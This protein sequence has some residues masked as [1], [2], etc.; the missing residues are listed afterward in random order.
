MRNG[1]VARTSHDLLQQCP[2]A[3]LAVDLD[4][5]LVQGDMLL[6]GLAQALRH[7]PVSALPL[8]GALLLKGRPGLKRAVALRAPFDPAELPYNSAVVALAQVWRA[9]GRRVVLATAADAGVARAI[10]AH[11]GLFDAVHASSHAGNLKG[12]AKAA[13]LTENYGEQ[14]FVYAG[15]STA[16]LHVWAKAV[17][18]VLASDCPKLYAQLVCLDIPLMRLDPVSVA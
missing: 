5:T 17:G 14:G 15:D 12:R 7:A 4:G 3:I 9:H 16:D 11:L 13:F 18:A 10:A 8:A 1:R 2:D 6:R